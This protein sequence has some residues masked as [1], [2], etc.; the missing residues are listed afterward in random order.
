MC[1]RCH[2]KCILTTF[3]SS[4]DNAFAALNR[5]RR[6]EQFGCIGKGVKMF[7]AKI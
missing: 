7:A 6:K 5:S 4:K 1:E 2:T 3:K